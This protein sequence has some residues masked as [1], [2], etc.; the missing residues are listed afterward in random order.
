MKKI[1]ILSSE[2]FTIKQPIIASGVIK[3]INNIVDSLNNVGVKTKLTVYNPCFKDLIRLIM[4]LIYSKADLIIIR[5]PGIIR[6]VFL[7]PII[8]LK[9]INGNI[10]IMDLPTP[11]IVAMQE[12]R[13]TSS[14]FMVIYRWISILIFYPWIL[15]PYSRIIQSGYEHPYFL[16]LIKSKTKL[17]GNGIKV[18]AIKPINFLNFNKGKIIIICVAQLEIWHGYDRLLNSLKT[19]FS[20]HENPFQNIEVFIVGDGNEKKNLEHLS[21]SLGLVD[22]VKFTGNL[23]GSELDEVFFKSNLA[24]ASLGSF[25]VNLKSSSPLKSREYTARGLPF[26]SADNDP[27]FQ[28]DVPFLYKVAN[29]SSDLDF[30]SI[31]SWYFNLLKSGYDFKR[32]REYA[33]VNLDFDNKVKQM[34]LK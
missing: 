30:D 9:R 24:V 22:W 3:K 5:F 33:E 29:D 12:I 20:I 10:I 6:T 18:S 19:Y 17:I 13:F 21:Q 2:Y 7:F 23:T 28:G 26:L 25:R 34:F 16:F 15:L 31:F 14:R 11:L 4:G 27:D 32:I 1:K 8:L